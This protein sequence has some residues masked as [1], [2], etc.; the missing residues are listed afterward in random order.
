MP[1]FAIVAADDGIFA[2]GPIIMAAQV[3]GIDAAHERRTLDAG[4]CIVAKQLD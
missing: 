4:P 2:V 3:V 1:R